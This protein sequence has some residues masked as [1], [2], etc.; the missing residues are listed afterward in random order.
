MQHAGGSSR[1]DR[2][3]RLGEAVPERDPIKVQPERIEKRISKNREL[4][5]A[6]VSEYI[7]SFCNRVRR[8]GHLG[9]VSP[10]EFET[11]AKQRYESVSTKAWE[12]QGSHHF[13][14]I[15][16]PAPLP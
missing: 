16:G 11:A 15:Q 7:E 8:H 9:G 14:I 12:L 4:A 10:E 3:V 13:A 5:T 1:S 2:G 6:D